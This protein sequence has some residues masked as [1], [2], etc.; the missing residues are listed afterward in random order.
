MSSYY[1]QPH[2]RRDEQPGGLQARQRRQRVAVAHVQD[3][4]TRECLWIEAD[5][6]LPGP[7]VTRVLDFV[8]ELCSSP[9][10]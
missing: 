10:V 1:H 4:N 8:A 2:G 9:P 7:R 6:S 5:P 3:D